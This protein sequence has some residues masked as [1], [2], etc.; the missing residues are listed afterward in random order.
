MDK[1]DKVMWRW[2]KG[3]ATGKIESIF[4]RK[5]KRTIKGAAI[6]RN[7]TKENPALLIKQDDGDKV[8]KLKSEIDL[9]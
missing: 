9:E 3:Q 4:P 1:G 6:V 8:L 2:G 7:G 5:V